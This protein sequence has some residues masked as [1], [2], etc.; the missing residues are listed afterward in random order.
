LIVGGLL[1]RA[2]DRAASADPGFEYEHVVVVEPSLASHGYSAERAR[3]YIQDLAQRI[4]GIDGVEDVSVTSTPPLGNLKMIGKLRIDG[5]PLDVYIHRVDPRYLPTMK[6][7]LLAGRNLIDGS[8]DAVIVS[9]SL[10]SR[11][12]PGRGA[13]DQSTSIKIGDESLKVIGIAGNARSLA[14]GDRDAA[15][16]YRLARDPDFPDMT[17]VARTSRP[18]ALLVPTFTAIAN[19]IDP[20]FKPRVHLLKDEF[21]GHVR[22]IEQS[23]LAVSLLGLIALAVSC[24]GVVGL[25]AYAVAARTREIGIRLALGAGRIHVL[26]SLAG[27]LERTVL[28]GLIVGVVGAFVLAQL[29]RRELYGVS[30]IDPV[31][32]LGAI[33]LFLFAIGLAALWPARRALAV[34][35]V[36]ALRYERD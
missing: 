31:A 22:D 28:G 1:V 30:T 18:S 20:Q 36:I 8:E 14:P 27:Q 9:A 6:I 3:T 34:D 2:F 12:W 24:L 33:V 32:Y 4:R 13:L 7:P 35:P 5:R 23:A 19:E 16:L 25:V 29:L 17:V 21:D 26:T 10:A 15:E 11:Y